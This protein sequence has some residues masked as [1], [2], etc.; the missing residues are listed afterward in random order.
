MMN[1][2]SGTRDNNKKDDGA[3]VVTTTE[4]GPPPPA[5]LHPYPPVGIGK[6]RC[7]LYVDGR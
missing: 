4:H 7:S 1:A 6:V 3:A 5:S 2:A